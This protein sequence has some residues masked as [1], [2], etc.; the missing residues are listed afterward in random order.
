MVKYFFFEK[1]QFDTYSANVN[2]FNNTITNRVFIFKKVFF[3]SHFC[4]ADNQKRVT[5]L[6]KIYYKKEQKVK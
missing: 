4:F 5:D 1:S 2:I 3:L 6:M